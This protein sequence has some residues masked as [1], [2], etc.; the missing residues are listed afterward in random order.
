MSV[1][2][3]AR[4]RHDNDNDT[5]SVNAKFNEIALKAVSLAQHDDDMSLPVT[6]CR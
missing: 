3:L 4:T 6:T 5:I 1:S 2:S